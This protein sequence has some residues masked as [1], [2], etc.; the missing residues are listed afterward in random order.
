[1]L[2]YSEE[3]LNLEGNPICIAGSRVKA[4]LLN[5]W[6]LPIGGVAINSFNILNSKESPKTFVPEILVAKICSF[7]G[8]R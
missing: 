2:Q 6:M 8:L 7:Q 4:I 1:M 3:I 5:G